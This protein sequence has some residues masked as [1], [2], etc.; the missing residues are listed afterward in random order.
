[1]SNKP[2]SRSKEDRAS[3]A[4]QMRR[5]REK[6]DKRQRNV[7]SIAI[8][9]IVVALIGTAAWAINKE[10]NEPAQAFVAPAPVTD[11][12]GILWDTEAATGEPAEGEPVEVVLYED[13]QCPACQAFEA[14]NG[15]FLQEQVKKGEISIEYRPIA[16]LDGASTNEYSSRALNSALC[17]LD[18]EGVKAFHEMHG[19]LFANQSPEGGAG[20]EDSVLIGLAEQAGAKKV[21]DCI[22]NRKFQPWILK[23]TEAARAAKVTGTPTVLVDGKKVIGE[24]RTLPTQADLQ[25]AIDA[26]KK[27]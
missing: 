4:E 19:L 2:P 7:I 1:M 11:D 8:A 18:A 21:E 22:E 26:A 5:E 10:G 16:F 24:G 3:R 23:A 14:A 15:P 12:F 25:K 20:N 9:V 13:F 17:V 6:A 27:G